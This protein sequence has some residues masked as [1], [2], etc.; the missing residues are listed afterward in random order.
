MLR[1]IGKVLV[2]NNRKN[3]IVYLEKVL[4]N[5]KRLDFTLGLKGIVYT[6]PTT[7]YSL[8]EALCIPADH[9]SNVDFCL[10]DVSVDQLFHVYCFL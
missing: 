10:L 6:S 8:V 2:M 4:G 3:Y 7:Q 9:C 1:E 5:V